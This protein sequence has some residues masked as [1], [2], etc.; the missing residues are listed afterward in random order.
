M[1]AEDY[2]ML[3]C[4][5]SSEEDLYSPEDFPEEFC[6]DETSKCCNN[7]FEG[8]IHRHDT[9]FMMYLNCYHTNIDYF[10]P[11]FQGTALEYAIGTGNKH[12]SEMI[13]KHGADLHS[14]CPEGN[15]ILSR[16]I[17]NCYLEFGSLLEKDI[18]CM[19]IDHGVPVQDKVIVALLRMEQYD[20]IRLFHRK[21][22][23]ATYIET[24]AEK[25]GMHLSID[26]GIDDIVHLCGRVTIS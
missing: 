17:L 14:I 9:C 25:E 12:Y 15:N 11:D 10:D 7:I 4:D 24:I 19:L 26:L 21:G 22:M 8:I 18:I 23:S 5:A 16:Y 20:I 6:S 2:D 13:I 3:S 1:A